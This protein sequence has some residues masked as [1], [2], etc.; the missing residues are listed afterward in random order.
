MGF[1]DSSGLSYLWEKIKSIIPT[2]VSELTNDK[3]YITDSFLYDYASS[4]SL[5]NYMPL[6]GGTFTGNIRFGS[7]DYYINSSGKF[8]SSSVVIKNSGSVLPQTTK[9][10][11]C[12]DGSHRWFACYAVTFTGTSADYAEYFEWADGNSDNADR[13]GLFVT[14][15]DGEKISLSAENDDFLG[16]ISAVPLIIGDDI[17]DEWQGK[18]LRDVFGEFIYD[19]NGNK[20]IS[21]DYQETQEYI[22]RSER[23]EWDMV[24]LIG[25][26]VMVDDGSCIVGGY[27]RPRADGSGRASKSDVPTRCRC[28][29]RIDNTHIKVFLKG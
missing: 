22:P 11:Y 9:T 2:K 12:G 28:M 21:E 1:L 5:S 15:S 25:K 17:S 4:S 18:Y 27:C 14:L 20:I 19:S 6:S 23:R 13:R 7:T 8:Y 16:I 3:G 24:G 26:L 29:K 10:G